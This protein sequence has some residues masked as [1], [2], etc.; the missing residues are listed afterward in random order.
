MI[1]PITFMWLLILSFTAFGLFQ[2]KYRVQDLRKD[3]TEINRQL[4]QERDAIHVLKAEW[5]YL[6][7]P[8]RLRNLAQRHLQLGAVTVAQ[9][10]PSLDSSPIYTVSGNKIVKLEVPVDEELT[11]DGIAPVTEAS[12]VV[13]AKVAAIKEA[14][15]TTLKTKT[16]KLATSKSPSGVLRLPAKPV[17]VAAIKKQPEPQANDDQVLRLPRHQQRNYPMMQPILT[18]AQGGR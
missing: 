8:D 10:N 6:N 14:S 17:V 2:I 4:E 7:Q 1:K 5:S 9:I 11:A 16:V 12:L 3:L 13:P 18:S 15:L